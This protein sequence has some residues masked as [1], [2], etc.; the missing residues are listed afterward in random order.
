[1]LDR[2]AKG[3]G[4]CRYWQDYTVRVFALIEGKTENTIRGDELRLCK[5]R[6]APGGDAGRSFYTSEDWFCNEFQPVA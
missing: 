6:P 2:N 3:C 4:N 1:M 5:F